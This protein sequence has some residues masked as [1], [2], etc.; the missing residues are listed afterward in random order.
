MP[1]PADAAVRAFLRGSMIVEVATQ[2]AKGRPFVTP[3]W[4]VDDG[5]ALYITTGPQTRAG[6]N[7]A[8]HPEVALLFHGERLSRCDQV[9]RMRGVATCHRALPSWPVLLRVAAKYYVSP[10]A[11][12]VELRSVRKW[13]LRTR[14][15]GQS[16]GGFGY[17]RIVPTA[18]V[19]LP[20][21][22]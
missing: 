17:I 4:F 21:P 15:Y 9:L 19:F 11:L 10:S 5:T 22:R 18:A 14:Y 20:R 1:S 12:P 16:T 2:S 7:V 13:S 8:H 3:L 6:K